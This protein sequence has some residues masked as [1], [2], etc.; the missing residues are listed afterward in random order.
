MPEPSPAPACTTT[1]WPRSTSSRT[2]AGVSATRYSSVLISE[3]TPTFISTNSHSLGCLG[4]DRPQ[5]ALDLLPLLWPRDQRRRELDD[6]VAAVV[7]AGDQAALEQLGADEAAQQVLDLGALEAL[8]GLLVLD[9]LERMEVAG[10]A[11]VADERDVAQA[12]EHAAQPGLVL[13]DVLEDALLLEDRDVGQRDPAAHRVPG[14]REAVD[15]RVRALEE[16]L[17]DPVGD[18]RGSHR[19]VGRRQALGRRD[20]VGLIVEALGPEPLAEPAERADDLVGDEQDVVLVADLADALEVALGRREAAAG[21]L[22]R[23]EEHGRDGVGALEADALVDR[24][25]QGLG[26][27]PGREPVLVGVRDVAAA[28]GERLE[29]LAQ[30]GDAGDGERAQRGPVVGGLAGDDLRLVRLAVELV[31]LADELDRR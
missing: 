31:E 8:L 25:R 23:L 13:A 6:G 18:D 10:A 14:E 29:G 17:G 7:G 16:R 15:E 27:E 12:V 4:E 30:R 24:L 22:G 28:R 11:H 3:G 5:H 19:R 2:P 21:V 26:A 9:E 1:E 20:D